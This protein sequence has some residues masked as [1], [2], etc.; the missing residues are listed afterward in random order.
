M[1]HSLDQR[2]KIDGADGHYDAESIRRMEGCESAERLPL[3]IVYSR[4][5]LHQGALRRTGRLSLLAFSSTKV[6][7]LTPEELYLS[8]A[9]DPASLAR[10]F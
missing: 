4:E 5:G 9:K 10:R 1:V 2:E 3:R 7:I 6:Q 8:A